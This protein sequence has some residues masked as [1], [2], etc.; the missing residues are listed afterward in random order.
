MQLLLKNNPKHLSQYRTT[1][2]QKKKKEKGKSS[3]REDPISN[4]DESYLNLDDN[5]QVEPK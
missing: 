4:P 5:T 2:M 3:K 1:S